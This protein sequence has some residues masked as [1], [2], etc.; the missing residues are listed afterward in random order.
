MI[1]AMNYV[2]P[3]NLVRAGRNL[4]VDG[5][6]YLSGFLDPLRA[7]TLFDQVLGE[8]D[9]RQERFSLFGREVV[10]PRLT[11]WYG[12]AG[13]AYRYS[14]ITR[15]A[16]PWPPLIRCLAAEVSMAVGW[17]FNYVLVNRYRDGGDMLGWHADD[18]RD[19]GANPVLG[20]VSVGA[21]R[22]FRI[23]GRDGGPSTGQVLDHGSLLLMWG[24]SQRRYKHCIPRTRKPLGERL[25]FTFRLTRAA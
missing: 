18:E 17:R 12:E 3:I 7:D 11:A 5:T 23:R 24:D 2:P 4:G 6:L 25:S 1:T 8:A 13:T 14:G 19:L 16:K 21:A 22:T 9:W 15:Q 10:A 20:A